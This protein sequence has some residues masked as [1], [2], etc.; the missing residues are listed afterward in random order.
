MK[1]QKQV[2]HSRK[3]DENYATITKKM[4]K[5]MNH[6]KTSKNIKNH[7]IMPSGISDINISISISL[8]LSLYLSLSLS[9]SIYIYI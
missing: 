7:E 8:S 2:F 6:A 9:L 1:E 5:I 4:P 3:I